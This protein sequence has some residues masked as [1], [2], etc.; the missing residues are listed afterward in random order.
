MKNAT[1]I[2]K[3]TNMVS[4]ARRQ[5]IGGG[6]PIIKIRRQRPQID[7]GGGAAGSGL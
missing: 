3:C 7:G 4:E 1:K 5:I 2:I 6:A